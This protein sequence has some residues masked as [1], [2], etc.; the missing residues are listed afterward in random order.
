MQSTPIV[1]RIVS[2]LLNVLMYVFIFVCL[3]AVVLSITSKKDVDGASRI[4]GYELRYIRSSSMEKSVHTDVSDYKIK[5]LPIKTLIVVQTVPKGEKNANDWYANLKKGDVL[6]IRYSETGIKQET[7]TH[8]LIEDPIPNDN[9]GYDLVLQGDNKG[10]EDD[11]ISL[12]K[13]I[14]DTS[15]YEQDGYNYVIGKVVADNY[16]FGVF[17]YAIKQP[18]GIVFIIIVPCVIIIILEIVRIMR[19]LGEEKDQKDKEE[20][21]KQNSE[22]EELKKQLAEL[23]QG[24]ATANVPPSDAE[25]G[26]AELPQGQSVPL[27]DSAKTEEPFERKTDLTTEN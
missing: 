12:G 21:E 26:Q 6:T 3:F 2:V 27:T 10:N 19:V 15:D 13:Q 11:P 20:K 14:I 17:L 22:I 24:L 23:R 9:G 1:K 25:G 5:S 8:R 4:L 18:L 16:Y 7:I